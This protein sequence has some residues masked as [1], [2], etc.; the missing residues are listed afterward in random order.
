MWHLVAVRLGQA[1]ITLWIVT[2]IVFAVTRASGDPAKLL[3][4]AEVPAA[5]IPQYRAAWGLDDP[6]YVQ[7][8]KFVSRAVRGD[9]GQS[10]RYDL[11]VSQLVVKRLGETMKL[12]LAA[13]LITILVAI[14]LGVAAAMYRG[15]MA[16]M[17]AKLIALIGQAVPSFWLGLMLVLIFAVKLRWFPAAGDQGFKSIIL[18]AVTLSSFAMAVVTRLTRSS[19]L[20]VLDTEYIK[21]V[22][23]KGMPEHIVIIKH[24]LR[25]AAIPLVTVLGLELAGMLGGAVVVET[26]FNWPGIGQLAVNAIFASDYPIIQAIV[27]IGALS[28]VIINLVVDLA[29]AV[30]DPRIRL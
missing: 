16:D 3:I 19:M 12:A 9:F 7:Y 23:A 4:P 13:E 29:Y 10:F 17:V 15:T 24:G 30:I 25:N 5:Q 26:I 11:P 27:V 22:R 6:L 18:P 14:P 1:V 28:F 20:D 21:L 2:M 8:G